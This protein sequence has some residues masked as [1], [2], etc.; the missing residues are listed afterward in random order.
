ML[1]LWLEEGSVFETKLTD[2]IYCSLH[3]YWFVEIIKQIHKI[4]LI[5]FFQT[6]SYHLECILSVDIFNQLLI[7]SS[8]N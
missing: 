3:A 1:H 5:K 4:L 6:P 7:P 2:N 8:L